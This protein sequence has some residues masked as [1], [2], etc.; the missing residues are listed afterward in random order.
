MPA[1]ASQ[2]KR[3]L[4]ASLHDTSSPRLRF[5]AAILFLVLARVG[6]RSHHLVRRQL[7]QTHRT[8]ACPASTQGESA[9]QRN[10]F[11]AAQMPGRTDRNSHRHLLFGVLR[12]H[13][14][15]AAEE[16]RFQTVVQR[17][18]H[19]HLHVQSHSLT[20]FPEGEIAEH[21]TISV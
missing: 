18:R 1:D 17:S 8:V 12:V 7:R 14:L 15:F 4:N 10:A 6:E 2:R 16:P 13:T 20:T 19:H 9:R 3:S 21:V 5:H 11:D